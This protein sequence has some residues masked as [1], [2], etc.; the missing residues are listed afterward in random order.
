MFRVIVA[1]LVASAATAT[2]QV[3]IRRGMQQIGSLETYAPVAVLAYFA[4]ALS[5]NYVVG[6]TIMN[7]IFYFLLLTVLSWTQVTVAIP[8]TA[9]EYGFAALLAVTLLQEA[10]PPIR[11]LGIVLIVVGV[12]LVGLGGSKGSM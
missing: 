6:G 5:N 9:L 1:M 7:G 2:G 12:A 11:W 8:F 4:Q 3:L 10:V